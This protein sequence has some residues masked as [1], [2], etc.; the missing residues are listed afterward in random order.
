[1]VT[2]AASCR[3]SRLSQSR[4][5]RWRELG[6]RPRWATWLSSLYLCWRFGNRQYFFE[7]LKVQLAWFSKMLRNKH[8]KRSRRSRSWSQGGWP[9]NQRFVGGPILSCWARGRTRRRHAWSRRGWCRWVSYP[10]IGRV[11]VQGQWSHS[12]RIGCCR[13]GRWSRGWGQPIC[14]R[15]NGTRVKWS[16]LWLPSRHNRGISSGVLAPGRNLV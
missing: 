15:V 14:V 10:I 3:S 9:R 2:L 16:V 1:M 8:R 6:R 5:H 11:I 7:I 12:K 13:A 4:H